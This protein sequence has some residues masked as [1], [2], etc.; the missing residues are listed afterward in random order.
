[1]C[2][3]VCRSWPN[4]DSFS[5]SRSFTA[6]SFCIVVRKGPSSLFIARISCLVKKPRSARWTSESRFTWW[7]HSSL[8]NER[9]LLFWRYC[10]SIA[11]F[12][13]VVRLGS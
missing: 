2:S 3:I 6:W 1:M 9:S 8:T 13:L 10:L 7:K 4:N 12:S 11:F 5:S